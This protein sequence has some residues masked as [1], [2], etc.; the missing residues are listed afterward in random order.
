MSTT[1]RLDLIHANAIYAPFLIS[2]AF[3]LWSKTRDGGW[4]ISIW[5]GASQ[6]LALLVLTA[7]SILMV[8]AARNRAVEKLYGGLDKSY[9]THGILGRWAVT[10]MVLHPLLLIP[11]VIERG[12][13]WYGVLLPIGPWPEGF[14]MARWFGVASFYLFLIL[15]GLTLYRRFSY[16]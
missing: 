9:K 3:W 16:E 8:I 15:T 1:R 2:T 10:G 12:I 4:D 7:F 5:L 14:E 11:V 6:I 13:P